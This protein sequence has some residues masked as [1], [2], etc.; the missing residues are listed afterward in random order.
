MQTSAPSRTV[1]Y[2]LHELVVLCNC[3]KKNKRVCIHVYIVL[4][5]VVCFVFLQNNAVLTK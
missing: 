2:K 1:V 3:S 4:F 5:V